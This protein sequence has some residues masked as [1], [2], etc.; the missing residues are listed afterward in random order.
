MR[1]LGVVL[2]FGPVA[3]SCSNPL[4]R[5]RREAGKPRSSSPCGDSPR[6]FAASHMPP[7]L[8]DLQRIHKL[9][10]LVGPE[11]DPWRQLGFIRHVPTP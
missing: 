1:P 6:Y 3:S 11:L 9:A 5:A 8:I 2:P 4:A 10:P 7:R